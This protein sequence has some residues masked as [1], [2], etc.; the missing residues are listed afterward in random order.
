[1]GQGNHAGQDFDRRVIFVVDKRSR[2]EENPIPD[3]R[4]RLPYLADGH[5]EA[6]LSGLPY[7]WWRLDDEFEPDERSH[8]HPEA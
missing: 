8:E 4:E 2:D 6:L 7:L 1:M 5:W 3:L